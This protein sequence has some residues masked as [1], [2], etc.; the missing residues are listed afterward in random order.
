M[1]VVV[2]HVAAEKKD[3][4][5]VGCPVNACKKLCLLQHEH[6]SVGNTC[7]CLVQG[8]CRLRRRLSLEEIYGGG[9][10]VDEE[11]A[12]LSNLSWRGWDVVKSDMFI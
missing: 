7:P 4:Y 3:E 1:A 9:G 11:G 6:R 5:A 12:D 8:S 10:D 2:Q